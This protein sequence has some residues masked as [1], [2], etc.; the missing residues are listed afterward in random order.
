[1]KAF[2]I[3]AVPLKIRGVNEL[4]FYENDCYSRPNH[5]DIRIAL[6]EFNQTFVGYGLLQII[7]L[8]H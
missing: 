3:E 4:Y 5:L 2:Y 1:M 6:R 8:T 7:I